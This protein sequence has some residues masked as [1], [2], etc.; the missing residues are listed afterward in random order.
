MNW[1]G[2]VQGREL[3]RQVSRHKRWTDDASVLAQRIYQINGTGVRDF[4]N[5][6]CGLGLCPERCPELTSQVGQL[7]NRSGCADEVGIKTVAIAQAVG[8]KPKPEIAMIDFFF[9]QLGVK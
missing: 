1:V 3:C 6:V 5:I 9:E 7:A 4:I 8:L 2:V